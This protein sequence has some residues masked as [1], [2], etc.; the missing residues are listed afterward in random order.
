AAFMNGAGRFW[1]DV[2]RYASRKRELLEQLSQTFLGLRDIRIE[3]AVSSLEVCVGDQSGPAM[4]GA[5]DIDHVEI[6]LLDQAVEMKIDEVLP[7]R[8]APMSKQ[9]RL[10]VLELKRLV[11]ERI[12]I[13]IDLPDRQIICRT[14][15]GV[16][17]AQFFRGQRLIGLEGTWQTDRRRRGHGSPTRQATR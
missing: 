15:I 6:E 16:H 17:L 7:G 12:R 1:S 9:P 5:C 10:D 4:P 11:Q 14:P 13:Q 8:S 3:L 2:A